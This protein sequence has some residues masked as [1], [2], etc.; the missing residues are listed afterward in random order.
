MSGDV[1]FSHEGFVNVRIK[2]FCGVV[3]EE[4]RGYQVTFSFLSVIQ[5]L[6]ISIIYQIK[7]NQLQNYK[8]LS[9]D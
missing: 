5:F 2:T 8:Q 7:L 4:T 6:I 3:N 1:K 9:N